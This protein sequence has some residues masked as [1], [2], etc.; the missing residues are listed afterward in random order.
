MIDESKYKTRGRERRQKIVRIFKHVTRVPR[1]SLLARSTMRSE[2]QRGKSPGKRKRCVNIKDRSGRNAPPWPGYVMREFT[3]IS[4]AFMAAQG[5]RSL[6]EGSRGCPVKIP[7]SKNPGRQ[8]GGNKFISSGKWGRASV[9]RLRRRGRFPRLSL[10][11][12]HGGSE[13][14]QPRRA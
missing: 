2:K 10:G 14:Y 7:L 5:K 11:N 1:S 4:T 13:K 6:R 3:R 9:H 8:A 12:I